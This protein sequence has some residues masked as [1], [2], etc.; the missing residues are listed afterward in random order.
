MGPL[1]SFL[2]KRL[3]PGRCGCRPASDVSHKWLVFCRI[4][5]RGQL[6]Q[7][8]QS[9]LYTHGRTRDRTAY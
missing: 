6:T 9:I 4:K 5:R 8:E 7:H 2:V 1:R 3:C